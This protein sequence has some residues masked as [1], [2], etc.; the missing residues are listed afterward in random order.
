MKH[1]NLMALFP[2]PVSQNE[3]N[4]PFSDDE[5]A[6]FD[7]YRNKCHKNAGNRITDDTYILHHPEMANLAKDILSAIDYYVANVLMPVDGLT[8]YITQSWLNFTEPGEYHHRHKHPN[9]IISGVLYINADP[10][11]DKI[12]FFD[13][14]KSEIQVK[15]KNYTT[16]NSGSWW[17]DVKTGDLLLFP[18]TLTHMVETTESKETR[19]SMAFNV[20]MSGIL[21][22]A[23]EL[24]ELKI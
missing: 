1:V 16:F 5:L 7:D 20:F 9:S 23:K 24:T 6:F 10:K 19:I 22:D 21:G 15:I 18:S 11:K 14:H 13:D 3:L 17:L 8:P 4:R 2:K 12:Q